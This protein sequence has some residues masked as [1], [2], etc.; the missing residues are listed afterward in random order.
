MQHKA[1]VVTGAQSSSALLRS[2]GRTALAQEVSEGKARSSVHQYTAP[3]QKTKKCNTA[4][5]GA[6]TSARYTQQQAVNGHTTGAHACALTP[7][8]KHP[9]PADTHAYRP[10]HAYA[11]QHHRHTHTPFMLCSSSTTLLGVQLPCSF[12]VFSERQ[13]SH[14]RCQKES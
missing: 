5:T 6:S 8:H 1:A 9:T 14:K 2:A 13:L 11:G 10:A 3:R 4:R 12:V 7:L